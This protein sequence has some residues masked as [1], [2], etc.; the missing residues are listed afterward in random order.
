MTPANQRR[1]RL[2]AFVTARRCLPSE[3]TVDV[4]WLALHLGIGPAAVHVLARQGWFP[5]P[6]RA[7]RQYLWN[8]Q[9]LLEHLQRRLAG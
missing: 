6:T 3:G 8:Y 7:G 9:M 4:E 2:T 1:G 5:P